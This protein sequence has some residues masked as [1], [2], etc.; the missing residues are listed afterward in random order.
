MEKKSTILHVEVFTY[1]DYKGKQAKYLLIKN[2]TGNEIY[3]N[4]GD[5]TYERLNTI[6]DEQEQKIE[7]DTD[8]QIERIDKQLKTQNKK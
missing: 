6:I 7:K 8:A 5:K 2:K 4:I 3:I 1:A